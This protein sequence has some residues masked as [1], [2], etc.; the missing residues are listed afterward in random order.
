MGCTEG[1]GSEA[2]NGALT[3]EGGAR[4]GYSTKNPESESV[5]GHCAGEA[6]GAM[7]LEVGEG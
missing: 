3:G 7:S 6:S 4:R 5:D 1:E 2:T